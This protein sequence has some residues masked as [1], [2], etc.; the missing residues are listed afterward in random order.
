MKILP[1]SLF[2]FGF[3]SPG[4]GQTDKRAASGFTVP[5][6]MIAS[7]ILLFVVGAMVCV[8][9]FGLR[10]YTLSGTKLMATASGR[11]TLNAMRDQIRSSQQI[12][13]G[14]FSNG[15]FTQ[16]PTGYPQIGNALELFSTT[17]L[18]STNF[19]LYYQS[20]SSNAIFSLD[21]LGNQQVLAIYQTN[22]YCFQA[23]DYRGNIL[24]NYLNNPVIDVIMS[25]SQ[26]EYPIG[27]VGSNAVNA[28]DYYY[29]RT[30]VT[31]RTRE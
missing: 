4:R 23:E 14:T 8:Q 3:G 20:P 22:Q 13:V 15:V 26:W 12:Y 24:S 5:E 30:R 17:N 11:K 29:L 10:V 6:V 7:A 2:P 27:F 28:Y 18:N 1:T 9:V 19:L 25:F 21:Y 31:R 16:V